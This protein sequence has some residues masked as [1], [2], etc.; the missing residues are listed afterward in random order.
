LCEIVCGETVPEPG[1]LGFPIDAEA[2]SRVLSD[3]G[4]AGGIRTHE[5]YLTIVASIKH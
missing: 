4:R 5:T 3:D 1:S 2:L